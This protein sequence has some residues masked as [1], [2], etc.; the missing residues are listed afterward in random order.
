MR[1]TVFA[2]RRWPSAAAA[3]VVLLAAASARAQCVLPDD[4]L[5]ELTSG[6]RTPLGI[7][8]SNQGNLIVSESGILGTPH[9]GRISILDNLGN[10]R[11][12]V[13]GLPSATND[14]GDSSGPAGILMQGRT[15]YVAIGIGDAIQVVAPGSPLRTANPNPASPIFTSVLA[16]H[17][18]AQVDTITTGYTL[19]MGDQQALANG[20]RVR[21]ANGQTDKAA[22]ELVANFPDYTPNP[23]PAFP[24]NV[25]GG[26][27]FDVAVIG[28]QLFVTDGGQNAVYRVDL[29][30]RAFAVLATFAPVPNP[31]FNP[32]PPPPSAG[33][34]FVEAVPTGIRESNGQLLI[35]LLR[36]F[37]FPAGTSVVEQVDPS[38][39]AHAPFLTG[40]K[41]AID[42]LPVSEDGESTDYLVMQHALGFILGGTGSL[43]RVPASGSPVVLT[44]CLTRPTSFTRD[45]K[46]G[47]VYATELAGR[48]VV[49]E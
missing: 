42:V 30:T 19:T 2:A 7:A 27:S 8:Q 17:F 36:G 14:A 11:T 28:D 46:S 3:A 9:T 49:I 29:L 23:T 48:V 1:G 26:N 39:G 15:L 24:A 12:L 33:G 40:F 4:A 35:T 38:T 44:S 45:D 43:T 34:P 21:L 47:T 31:L 5:P 25:R 13:D 16:I 10:S 18:S 41:T 37:P 22:I 6:L 20:E 32:A